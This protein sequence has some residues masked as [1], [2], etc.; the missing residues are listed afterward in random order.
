MLFRS[1]ALQLQHG[2]M[3]RLQSSGCRKMPSVATAHTLRLILRGT[4]RS[5]A[6]YQDGMCALGA[7]A[8]MRVHASR[9]RVGS[10]DRMCLLITRFLFWTINERGWQPIAI[11]IHA[12]P[13][14]LTHVRGPTASYTMTQRLKNHSDEPPSILV[15]TFRAPIPRPG[16]VGDRTRGWGARREVPGGAYH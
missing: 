14:C 2:R 12:T 9:E 15:W 4:P 16:S 6:R 7:G 10:Q 13:L 8:R 11:Q 3:I 5:C 1:L